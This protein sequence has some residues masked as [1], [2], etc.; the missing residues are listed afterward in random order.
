MPHQLPQQI[1]PVIL[2]HEDDWAF[3]E[4]IVIGR[5]P[6]AAV[7]M[8]VGERRVEAAFELAVS[9]DLGVNLME[10]PDGRQHHFRRK[11]QA[12]NCRPGRDGAIVRAV[13]RTPRQIAVE[14]PLDA[15]DPKRRWPRAVAGGL[16][17]TA[18]S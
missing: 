8:R 3:V 4:A 17:F 11:G 6:A 9:S 10:V 13:R 15:L 5:D 12:S 14:T 1:G 7:A 18:F 16:S 2:G